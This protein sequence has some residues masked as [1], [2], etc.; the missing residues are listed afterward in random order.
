MIYAHSTQRNFQ[1]AKVGKINRHTDAA[2]IY[3]M[4]AIMTNDSVSLLSLI[5]QTFVTNFNDKS[6]PF[7]LTV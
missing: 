5:K 7:Q 3:Y 4:F 6:F 1:T 2:D